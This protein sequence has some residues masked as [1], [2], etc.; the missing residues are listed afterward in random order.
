M[1]RNH[2]ARLGTYAL[3]GAIGAMA[4]TAMRVV[5][6]RLNLLPKDPPE[7]I[8]EDALPQFLELVPREYRDEAI[9]LAHWVYG[10]VGGAM[11][12]FLPAAIRRHR[13]SGPAYGIGT[14][15]FFEGVL[16]PMLGLRKPS[17]RPT[18]ERAAIIAD[19]VLYGLVVA[20]GS[21]RR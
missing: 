6:A 10:A 15:S 17:E 13:W 11:F 19:H 9:E 3:R 20:G 16:A 12:V 21:R 2:P 7:E 5:T 4:M 18:T 8:F 14:W 1:T